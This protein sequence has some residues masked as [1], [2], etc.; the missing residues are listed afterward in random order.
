MNIKKIQKDLN[1]LYKKSGL[2][3][4]I[5]KCRVMLAE[6]PNNADLHTILGDLYLKAILT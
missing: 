2:N 5:E 3:A 1:K 4:A 6:S